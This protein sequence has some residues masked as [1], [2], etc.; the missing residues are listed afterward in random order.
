MSQFIK[1][2]MIHPFLFAIIPILYFFTLK[3]EA[4][5]EYL[6][7]SIFITVGITLLF[8][9]FLKWITKNYLKS[10][11]MIS[12]SLLL[13]IGYGACYL[14]FSGDK[15]LDSEIS[16]SFLLII[17]FSSIIIFGNYVLIKTNKKLNK[18]SSLLNIMSIGLTISVIIFITINS[19]QGT[20]IYS[21][22]NF[23]ILLLPD[24]E[25]KYSPDIY[26][27]LLDEY[28]GASSL[29]NN[30][31]FNNSEFYSALI[32]IGFVMPD[33]N[34]SN[35][36]YTMLSVPSMLNMQYLNFLK[37][38]MDSKS[39]NV[40]PI[41][42]ILENNLVMKN[43]DA[44]GYHIVSAFAGGDAVGTKKII[45]E[46]LCEKEHFQNQVKTIIKKVVPNLVFESL[47]SNDGKRKQILCTF[48]EIPKI[49][50]KI[51]Q[52]IFV[53]AH[54]ALPH[55]PFVFDENGNSVDFSSKI[56]D[57]EI[58][59]KRYIDQL[60][61]TNKKVIELV[62]SLLSKSENHPIII[63]QSDHGERTGID[64]ENPTNDML[65]QGFNNLNAYYLPNS[66]ENLVYDSIS[67]VNSFRLIFNEYF[68]A[69]FEVIDDKQYWLISDQ[70][71]YEI[72]EVT[73]NLN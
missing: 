42:E 44:Q 9:I 58:T 4:P 36:P 62:E 69:N 33:T 22:E 20:E 1:F 73:E 10:G 31:D 30:F 32:Q 35:Y 6:A 72:R 70:N 43:L 29:E 3:I 26:Y 18:M 13:F 60:K 46:K 66:S 24:M 50:N 67:P 71:P 27:I 25:Q 45:D 21:N 51:S 39:T 63:I 14:E 5:F 12:F 49:K 40:K 34:Y 55:S 2:L 37:D 68:N 48:S 8:I 23:E 38:E 16:I 64:W 53:Y 47:D 15:I 54:M 59:K 61:F 65:M 56:M 52:P 19:N 11:I 57:D 7:L 41:I 17:L 28:A